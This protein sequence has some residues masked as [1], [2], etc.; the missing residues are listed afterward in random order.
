MNRHCTDCGTELSGEWDFCPHCGHRV[1]EKHEVAM[2]RRHET[3]P[4][5]SSYGGFVYGA[6]AAPILI[7]SGI[8]IC[9]TG[10]GIFIGVP[11]VL[12]GIIAPLAGTMLGM[13]EHRGKCP[14]CGV[15][16]ITGGDQ[17]A[18][19]CPHCGEQF[20]V[21]DEGTKHAVAAH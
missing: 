15:R 12:L 16:V 5:K 21:V 6:I 4:S 2:R 8:M 10:W 20:A 1:A 13:G 3:A 19:A 18:H 17:L 14:K 7:I 11:I 9:L